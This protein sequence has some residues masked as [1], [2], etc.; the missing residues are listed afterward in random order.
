LKPSIATLAVCL[1]FLAAGCGSSSSSSSSTSSASASNTSTAP[2]PGTNPTSTAS[3]AAPAGGSASTALALA[4]SPTGLLKYDKSSLTA[5]AGKVTVKFTNASPLPHNVVIATAAG[6][7]LAQTPT[8]TG[9]TKSVTASL[10]PGT[11][12]FY[13]SVPGHRQAGMQGTLVVR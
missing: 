11:Y 9:G 12:T 4:A 7:V 13:C 1:V 6:Q 10:K 2:V 5:N 3:A 8:F